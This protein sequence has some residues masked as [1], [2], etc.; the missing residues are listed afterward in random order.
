MFH[1]PAKLTAGRPLAGIVFDEWVE[2]LP[3]SDALAQTKLEGPDPLPA[4][5]ELT[6]VSFHFDRPDAKAPQAILLAVPPTRARGWT[7][8]VLA[9]VVRDT[10]ELAKLR[11]VDVGALP[12]VDDVAPGI[13]LNK[14]SPL[15]SLAFDFWVELADE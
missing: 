10:L 7:E 6:G 3:G 15:G 14:L 9:L 11:A 12:L 2:L 4:E 8:D 5:S 1:Q 13:R